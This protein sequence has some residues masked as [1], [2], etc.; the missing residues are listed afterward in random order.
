LK[1]INA[2]SIIIDEGTQSRVA[3][4]EDTVS[5]YAAAMEA[6]AEFPPVT[7]M[8]DGVNYYLADGYHRLHA[9]NRI[10][11]ASIQADV[12]R[13]TLRDAIWWSYGANQTHG[14]RRTHADKRQIVL[15]LLND[16][17]WQDLPDREIARHCGF[18]HPF[19][20]RIRAEMSGNVSTPRVVVSKKPQPKAAPVEEESSYEEDEAVQSL[21]AENQA[22]TDRLAVAGMEGTEEDK[23]AATETIAVLR[24][25]IVLLELENA[26]LK[27]SRDT[28]QK[29]NAEL[30]KSI[31]SYQRQIKKQSA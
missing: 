2:K 30:K 24:S 1:T 5:D 12:Q 14:L 9:S 13:G 17:E 11:R 20:G 25:Q 8:Y 22:L 10:G 31:A 26:S 15:N 16:F 27:I 7:V 21:I 18:S 3:I 23:A 4:C 29:E 6:G 28:F 19:I